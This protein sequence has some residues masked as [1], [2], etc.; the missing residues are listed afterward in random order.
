MTLTE[1]RAKADPI[2][3]DFWLALKQKQDAYFSKHGKYFQLLITPTTTVTDG[4][5]SVFT[6]TKPPDE[7]YATDVDF[8][9]ATKI[10]FQI[11]IHEWCGQ[12]VGYRAIVRAVVGSET[13]IRVRDSE[14]NDTGWFKYT[15]T[16]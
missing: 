13:Y 12:L 10:P 9:W 16:N 6:T 2:L 15:K 5:D 4:Y 14:Q 7:K 1:L 8:T 3:A 11:E